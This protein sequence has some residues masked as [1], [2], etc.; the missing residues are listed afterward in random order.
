MD[1][2]SIA[3]K[4]RTTLTLPSSMFQVEYCVEE[5]R[6]GDGDSSTSYPAS[7]R[8][9]RGRREELKGS[10]LPLNVSHFLIATVHATV[11]CTVGLMPYKSATYS[12]NA[13][14]YCTSTPLVYMNAFLMK[15][16]PDTD[17]DKLGAPTRI[18]HRHSRIRL[19]YIIQHS[20]CVLPTPRLRMTWL[21]ASAVCRKLHPSPAIS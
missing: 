13:K 21:L 2:L 15:I 5:Y 17:S 4:E 7:C 3:F 20:T 16:S 9:L 14:S 11:Q 12:A 8:R 6:G 1:E 10:N 18:I 19:P